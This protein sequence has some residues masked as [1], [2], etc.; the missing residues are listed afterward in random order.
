MKNKLSS[1]FRKFFLQDNLEKD[2]VF[3]KKKVISPEEKLGKITVFVR[4]TT[5]IWKFKHLFRQTSPKY[6][7]NLFLGMYHNFLNLVGQ[8]HW[9]LLGIAS[10]K[11]SFNEIWRWR[12]QIC[13]FSCYHTLQRY[14]PKFPC[15]EKSGKMWNWN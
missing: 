7:E 3:S 10:L 4:L 6:M 12:K 2:L 1:Y 15:V 8:F 11:F 5:V 9:Q 13:Q 14:W